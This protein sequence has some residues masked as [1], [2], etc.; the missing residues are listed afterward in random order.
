MKYTAD[1]RNGKQVVRIQEN[2]KQTILQPHKSQETVYHSPYGFNWGNGS[3]ESAQLALAILIDVC[4]D[5]DFC[6]RVYQSFLWEIIA[7]LP[8]AW[9]MERSEIENWIEGTKA[10]LQQ[11]EPF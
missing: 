6:R 2:G 1:K 7:H 10:V 8:H 5:V 3:S 9:E 4:N 11:G